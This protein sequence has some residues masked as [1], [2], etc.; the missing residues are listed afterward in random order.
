ML[1]DKLK[2]MTTTLTKQIKDQAERA[3][4]VDVETKKLKQMRVRTGGI[5]RSEMVDSYKGTNGRPAKIIRPRSKTD[6]Y[7]AAVFWEFF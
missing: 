1:Q 6:I 4:E 7:W 2:Y 5:T 3:N